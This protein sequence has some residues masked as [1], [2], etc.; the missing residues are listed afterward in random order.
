MVQASPV[1]LSL[2]LTAAGQLHVPRD[3]PGGPPRAP[4]PSPRTCREMSLICTSSV[5]HLPKSLMSGVSATAGAAV[6]HSLIL[7]TQPQGPL[8]A[9]HPGSHEAPGQLP[10]RPEPRGTPPGPTGRRRLPL[11]NPGSTLLG[12]S[13][14]NPGVQELR[15][16]GRV[17]SVDPA[18]PSAAPTRDLPSRIAVQNQAE[19]MVRVSAGWQ[20]RTHQPLP[21]SQQSDGGGRA[22]TTSPRL[23]GSVRTFSGKRGEGTPRPRGRPVA[24][25]ETLGRPSDPRPRGDLTLGLKPMRL[26]RL[27]R[28]ARTTRSADTD[29][30]RPRAAGLRF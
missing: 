9:W 28:S 13:N 24:P 30:K 26:G 14:P 22:P 2:Q 3:P 29:R 20:G 25:R 23:P 11:R 5:L 4:H 10:A 7:G 1:H 8:T 16:P 21:G 18:P 12:R 15:A 19:P 27:G 6:S 17:H